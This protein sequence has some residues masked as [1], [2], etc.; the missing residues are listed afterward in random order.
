MAIIIDFEH[1]RKNLR[2]TDQELEEMHKERLM[3]E[4]FT[5]THNEIQEMI[6]EGVEDSIS[7]NLPEIMY[8]ME[9]HLCDLE[10]ENQELHDQLEKLE[11]NISELERDLAKENS[12]DK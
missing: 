2:P 6:R 12:Q 4:P 3:N 5:T 1:Y 8:E 10:D 11:K 9:R 7:N